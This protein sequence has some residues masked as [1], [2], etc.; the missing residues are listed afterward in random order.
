MSIA[1]KPWIAVPAVVIMLAACSSPGPDVNI[2][3]NPAPV[4]SGTDTVIVDVS[5]VPPDPIA[6]GTHGF[7]PGF[8]AVC[9]AMNWTANCSDPVFTD[10]QRVRLANGTFGRHGYI[11]P[12][13]GLQGWLLPDF[14]TPRLVALVW[15]KSEGG[16]PGGTDWLPADLTC[17]YLQAQG[18]GFV[19]SMQPGSGTCPATPGQGATPLDVEAISSPS[20]FSSGTEAQQSAQVPAVARF[21][22]GA[23]KSASADVI[24]LGTKCAARWCVFSP[25]QQGAK[26]RAAAHRGLNPQ[27]RTWA[28]NGW[29]DAQRLAI[30]TAPN[31]EVSN[32]TSSVIADTGL[33]NKMWLVANGATHA[34]TIAQHAAT[35]VMRERPGSTTYS[36][37]WHLQQ[38]YN[39]LY[40]WRDASNTW[41]GEI[42][43]V[44]GTTLYRIRIYVEKK[45]AGT[46]PPATARFRWNADDEEVWVACEGGCCYVSAF[47]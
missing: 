42:Q 32:L 15:F 39:E 17:L 38:G 26:P 21:H 10:D 44:V 2:Q 43:N 16:Q 47:Q 11:A 45:H 12:A 37:R 35:I 36:T 31:L 28:I 22:E 19:G 27:W 9:Q 29:S 23:K 20:A 30:G 25:A 40:L 3:F 41:Y 6:L 7:S 18:N 8:L 14:A 33:A 4:L 5:N 1:S 34:P 13:P 24:L 46:N